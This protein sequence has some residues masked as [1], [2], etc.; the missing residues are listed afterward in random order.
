[1]VFG[2]HLPVLGE[3]FGAY[4]ESGLLHPDQ[5]AF[6]GAMYLTQTATPLLIIDGQR[7]PLPVGR[8]PMYRLPALILALLGHDGPTIFDYTAPPPGM[9]VRALPGLHLNLIGDTVELCAG[10][11]LSDTCALSAEWLKR[12]DTL[13]ADLFN[14]AQ[15]ALPTARPQM[16]EGP[17]PVT[18]DADE[19][20]AD[21]PAQ[22]T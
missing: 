11:P 9:Q 20:P 1:M 6:T 3:R 10:A 14:G 15:Y 18:A 4:V 7:G 22:E 17:Q 19:P 16:P 8:L 12:I 2:D 5:G 13:A 21:D